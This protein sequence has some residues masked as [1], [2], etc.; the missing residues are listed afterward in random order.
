[1][2]HGEMDEGGKEGRRGER[3]EFA[4]PGLS[5]F[6]RSDHAANWPEANRRIFLLCWATVSKTLS[7][8]SFPPP[9]CFLSSFLSIM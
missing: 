9:S 1:M 5:N 3:N 8:S 4:V 6:P 2:Q 7:L